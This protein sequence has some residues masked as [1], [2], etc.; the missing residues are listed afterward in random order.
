MSTE[1]VTLPAATQPATTSTEAT[2]ATA[3]PGN[4][5]STQTTTQTTETTGVSLS[6]QQ[7]TETVT[8]PT[9]EN[10]FSGLSQEWQDL[11]KSKGWK[12][13]D[14][15]PKGYKELET[16]LSTTRPAEAPA[17]VKAYDEAIKPPANAAEIGYNDGFAKWFKD[18]AFE[19]KVPVSAVKGLHD[20]FV[21]WAGEQVGATVEAQN[22]QI[23]QRVTEAGK[24]LT[25]LWGAPNNPKFARSLDMSM[26]AINTLSPNLKAALVESGVIANVGGKE[27]VVNATIID[28]FSKVG[29]AMF[30][31]DTLYGAAAVN[32]N[33]FDPKTLDLTKQ[34]QI[35][36]QDKAKAASLIRALQPAEQE[37]YKGLLSRLA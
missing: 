3:Q 27:M 16:K 36:K 25:E 24:S 20:S 37:R 10:P 33:P 14:D 1:G 6:P 17:D 29:A 19:H 34:G 2:G 30:A 31:E 4:G 35:I 15:I 26:R 32:G 9:G 8:A 12:T 21:K 11:A 18:A 7:T 28:A 13:L 22:A 5:G 23:A